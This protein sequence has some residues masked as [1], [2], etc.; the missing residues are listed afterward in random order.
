MTQRPAGK[1]QI[2]LLLVS[3]A[4]LAFQIALLQILATV[5]MEPPARFNARALRD[6]TVK[7]FQSLR[8]IDPE[9]VANG[10]VG[11]NR[12]GIFRG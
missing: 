6:E 11:D 1:R 5:T 9:M 8:P 10:R 12:A 2:V 4:L 7:V 3:A